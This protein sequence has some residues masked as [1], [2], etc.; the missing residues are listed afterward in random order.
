ME[1]ATAEKGPGGVGAGDGGNVDSGRG[2][3]DRALAPED[4]TTGGSS[5]PAAGEV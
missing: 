3:T 1:V 4:Q 5:H 2:A